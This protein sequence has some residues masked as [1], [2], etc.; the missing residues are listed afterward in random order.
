MNFYEEKMPDDIIRSI[1]YARISSREE[2]K[3]IPK[4]LGF[5]RNGMIAQL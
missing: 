5:T 3:Y 1:K 2:Q 4:F